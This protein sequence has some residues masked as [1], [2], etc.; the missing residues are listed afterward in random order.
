MALPKLNDSPKYDLVIPSTKKKVRFRPYLVKE[1][2]VLMI[3]MESEDQSKIFNAIADTIEACIEEPIAKNKLTTFDI[4]Y[5]FVQIRSKSVG[6]SID[7]DL[8]CSKC[9]T[10]N[11][12]NIKLDDVKVDIPEIENV[13]KIN[14]DISIQMQWPSFAIIADKE[15]LENNS[16]T[17]QTFRMVAK[18][19]DAVLTEDERITF[20][21]ESYA[22][23]MAF[24][25]SL[26]SQQFNEI[27]KFIELL[28]S[29]EHKVNFNCVSCGEENEI[30][31]RGMSDFF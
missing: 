25:E 7:L 9:E 27:R 16:G 26:S 21:D 13:I 17:E 18:C 5:M 28:P 10:P 15:L 2:K 23:Q 29:M 6:E 24:I 12:I 4:E 8:P 19:I 22:D 31:L 14:D 11:A 3:A 30:T 1:E 20:K